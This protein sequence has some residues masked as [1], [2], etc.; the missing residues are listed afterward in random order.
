VPEGVSA[1]TRALAALG[2]AGVEFVVV[3]VGGI[4]FYARTPAQAFAT[5]DLDALLA[6]TVE[7]LQVSLRVLAALGYSF[8][9]GGEP[10]L[11]LT[12]ED[13]LARVLERGASLSAIHPE[14]SQ[15]DLMTSIAGFSYA[16]LV[17]DATPFEVSGV[18][19][20]VGRLEKLLE[21]K[22]VSG[23]PKDLEFLR[24]FE[25]RAAD[26]DTPDR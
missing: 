4:N 24:A 1:F 8:E 18:E 11:E 10:F 5:L 13:T 17:E 19:V 23:R 12:D 15:L 3:G 14:A 20:R 22:Q 26:D 25:A 16:E 7:N 2:E 9:A 6:P 21:S